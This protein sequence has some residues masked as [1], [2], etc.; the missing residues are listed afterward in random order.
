MTRGQAQV[1]IWGRPEPGTRRPRF[2]RD[3]IAAVAMDIADREGFEAVTM[4][5]VA[6]ELDAG[7]MS[8]YHYVRSKDDLVALM[9]DALMGEALVPPA[10]LPSEWRDALAAVAR[11]TRTA[12]IAHPWALSALQSAQLG[13][14]A[15]RHFEQSLAAV[16][17]TGLD[18]PAKFAL[19]GVV[20]DYVFGNVLHSSEAT[21]RRQAA[22]ASP[23]AVSAGIEFGLAQLRTGEYPHTSAL[24]G[25]GDPRSR[26]EEAPGPAMDGESLHQQFE[27]GLQAVLDGVTL[28]M[29]IANKPR[30]RR[31][32][33]SSA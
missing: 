31:G 4:R 8:L 24:L 23:E 18:T 28:R 30:I 2:S 20:D 6:T 12:L 15:M 27:Q 9:D 14:N 11:S 16:A 26:I 19:L 21:N 32:R 1:P 29:G 3:Q 5:R 33:A 13:P 22:E 17:T 7:T 25:D 10:E